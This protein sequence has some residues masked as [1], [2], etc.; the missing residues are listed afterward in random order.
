MAFAAEEA[1]VS[2][3]TVAMAGFRRRAEAMLGP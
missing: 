1:R 2:G 3:T